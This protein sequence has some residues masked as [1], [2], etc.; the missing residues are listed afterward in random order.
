MSNKI[1]MKKRSQILSN[2][3]SIMILISGFFLINQSL[4]SCTPEAV[5]PVVLNSVTISSSPDQISYYEGDALDL[6]G[7]EVELLYSD[8]SKILV[9]YSNFSSKGLEVNIPSGTVLTSDHSSVKI[10]HSESGKSCTQPLTVSAV[11]VSGLVIKSAPSKVSYY[12]GDILSLEGL[13]VTVGYNNETSSDISYVDFGS[14]GLT[15]SIEDG[16][17][18]STTDTK[19]VISSSGGSFSVDQLLTVSAVEINGLVIKSAPSKISYTEDDLLSLDGLVVTVSYNNGTSSDIPYVDFGSNGLTVSILDGA[20]LSTTDTQIV[21]SATDTSFSVNQAITVE[22]KGGTSGPSYST[23]TDGRD[24]KVYNT[25]TIGDQV[26]MAENLAYA[27]TDGSIPYITSK[28]GWDALGS[29]DVAYSYYNND[30]SLGYGCLYTWSAAMG[31]SSSSHS[32]PSGVRGI[33]PSGWHLPSDSEWTEL[34]D[35]LID[36]GYNIYGNARDTRIAKSMAS[37]TG[38]ASYVDSGTI[39][40]DS[41]ANN[42]SGFTA[43][44]GGSHYHDGNFYGAEESGFW[45][46]STHYSN[47]LAYH[48]SLS[49]I[50]RTLSRNTPYKE[51]GLSVRCLRD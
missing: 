30:S 45:W 24:S 40:Y 48:R 41:S 43:L 9:G 33:C 42:S 7:L 10:T 21:I 12:V 4:I 19:V 37:K 5:E 23:M 13:V 2:L 44:P 6:S 51:D 49:K 15:V 47:G 8:E 20:V 28:E 3:R 46:S 34:E 22:A 26:W 32:N 16:A 50:A 31:G 14:N 17:V 1:N 29:Y 11:E 38:W 18:L 25:V 27:P 35:Y 39:G 36:N